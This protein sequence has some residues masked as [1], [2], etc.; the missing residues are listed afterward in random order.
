MHICHEPPY[1]L[2]ADFAS[3]KTCMCSRHQNFALKLTA[4]KN[5]CFKCTDNPDLFESTQSEEGIQV[6]F[7]SEEHPATI[8]Y[9]EWEKKKEDEKYR[10]K[11]IEKEK[12]CDDFEKNVCG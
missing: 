12:T 3:K 8:R 6:L 1:M 10:F 4:L 2:L 5:A 7:A 11:L 9:S